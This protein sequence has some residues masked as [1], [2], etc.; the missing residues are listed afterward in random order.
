MGGGRLPKEGFVLFSDLVVYDLTTDSPSIFTFHSALD[1]HPLWTRD[2]E[3]IFWTSAREGTLDIF[4]KAADGTGRAE[5]LTTSPN[6]QIASSWS[7]DGQ[8]LV[9]TEERPETGT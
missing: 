4:W 7:A 6:M 3:R 2:G 1:F 8:R 9:L 5:R